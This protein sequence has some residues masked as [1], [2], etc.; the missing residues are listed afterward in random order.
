MLE[1]PFCKQLKIWRGGRAQKEVHDIFGV[2]LSAYKSWEQ[3]NKTPV[4]L[5]MPEISRRMAANPE[6]KF[7]KVIPAQLYS[8]QKKTPSRRDRHRMQVAAEIQIRK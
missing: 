5:A 4:E 3:N 1:I 6:S 2:C 7:R 8:P